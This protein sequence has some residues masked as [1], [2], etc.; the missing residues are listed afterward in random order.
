MKEK[1][2][3]IAK[4]VKTYKSPFLNCSSQQTEEFNRSFGGRAGAEVGRYISSEAY[5]GCGSRP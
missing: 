4:D 2:L 5:N 1:Y 3:H